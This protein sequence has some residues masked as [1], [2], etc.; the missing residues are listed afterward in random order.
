M[1]TGWEEITDRPRSVAPKWEPPAQVAAREAREAAE[2][3]ELEVKR[4]AAVERIKKDIDESDKHETALV[5]IDGARTRTKDGTAATVAEITA[6]EK[7]IMA[8]T[9][10]G[11]PTADLE[12]RRVELLAQ[13]VGQENLLKALEKEYVETALKV[14]RPLL[15]IELIR[16]GDPRKLREMRLAQ[17]TLQWAMARENDVADRLLRNPKNQYLRD[18]LE[19]AKEQAERARAAEREATAA[20]LTE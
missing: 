9:I 15:T 3:D 12:S 7:E 14:L 20:V 5:G 1:S 18:E 4:K 13:K 17:R 16:H 19:L 8:G 10:S 11:Q 2:A 6:V